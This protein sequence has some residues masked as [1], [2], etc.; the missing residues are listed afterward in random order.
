MGKFILGA[1]RGRAPPPV[2]GPER[3]ACA[4][5]LAASLAFPLALLSLWL[6]ELSDTAV[7]QCIHMCQDEVINY[8]LGCSVNLP[9]DVTLLYSV[10]KSDCFK[11]MCYRVGAKQQWGGKSWGK[12]CIYLFV[13]KR[14]IHREEI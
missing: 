14:Q 7:K 9:E 1:A 8:L 5:R 4:R 11:M 6:S 2:S 10:V 12:Q 3:R 13:L